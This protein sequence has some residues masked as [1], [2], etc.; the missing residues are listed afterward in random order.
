MSEQIF[1]TWLR[2]WSHPVGCTTSLWVKLWSLRLIW[3]FSFFFLSFLQPHLFSLCVCSGYFWSDSSTETVAK[4]SCHKVTWKHYQTLNPAGTLK[5]NVVFV[6]FDLNT[7]QKSVIFRCE[8][9]S[10]KL[11]FRLQSVLRV[12]DLPSLCPQDAAAHTEQTERG[13]RSAGSPLQN[14]AQRRSHGPAPTVSYIYYIRN[15]LILQWANQ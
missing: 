3:H 6:A 13:T 7:M 1:W 10:Q 8:Q 9:Q 15:S 4:V 11:K 2:P 14:S 12:A 5:K